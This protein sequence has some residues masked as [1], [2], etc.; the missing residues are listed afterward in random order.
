[1]G[2]AW[3]GNGGQR[4]HVRENNSCCVQV[5]YSTLAVP[6]TI[7]AKKR[8]RLKTKRLTMHSTRRLDAPGGKGTTFNRDI[9]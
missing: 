7:N 3:R 8:R 6:D 4:G 2:E 5:L 9:Q 1:M